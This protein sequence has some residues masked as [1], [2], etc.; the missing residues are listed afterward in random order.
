M[1]EHYIVDGDSSFYFFCC[2]VPGD[3]KQKQMGIDKNHWI[4]VPGLS[5]LVFS[6]ITGVVLIGSKNDPEG[7]KTNIGLNLKFTR[8]HEE[9]PGYTRKI[10]DNW[11]YSDKAV[12]LVKQYGELCPRLFEYL[13]LGEHFDDLFKEDVFPTDR[14]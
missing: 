8:K 5:K 7:K 2:F 10:N 6:R 4:G 3:T 12:Q 11:L 13:T 1:Y 14:Y 9:I